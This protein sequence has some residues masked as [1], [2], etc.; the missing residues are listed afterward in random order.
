MRV[1]INITIFNIIFVGLSGQLK[2][3]NFEKFLNYLNADVNPFLMTGI[4]LFIIYS[5]NKFSFLNQKKI[6]II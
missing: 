5:Y 2:I 1:R 6:V 3:Y 4:F